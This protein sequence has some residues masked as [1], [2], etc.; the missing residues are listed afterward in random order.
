MPERQVILG[1]SGQSGIKTD[2]GRN[3]ETMVKSKHRVA[4]RKEV[5]AAQRDKF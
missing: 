2:G 4:G 3:G 5:M 1:D